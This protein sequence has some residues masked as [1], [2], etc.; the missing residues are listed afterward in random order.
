M[1]V[2]IE[3]EL[4]VVFSVLY[5]RRPIGHTPCEKLT[6]SSSVNW[7]RLLQVRRWGGGPATGS[8]GASR[9]M[10]LMYLLL[11]CMKTVIRS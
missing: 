9:R 6:R 11:L 7:R 8:G 1:V 5:K 2:R 3:V 10:A 4:Y